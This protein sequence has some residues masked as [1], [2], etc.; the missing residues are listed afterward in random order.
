M[1]RTQL[2]WPAVVVV[3]LLVVSARYGVAENCDAWRAVGFPEH[4]GCTAGFIS[5]C[6]PTGPT[7]VWRHHEAV[8]TRSDEDQDTDCHRLASCTDYTDVDEDTFTYSWTLEVETPTYPFVWEK[9]CDLAGTSTGATWSTTADYE[10]ERYYR[11]VCWVDDTPGDGPGGDDP[12][13]MAASGPV[14]LC[15]NFIHRLRFQQGCPSQETY[16]MKVYVEWDASCAPDEERHLGHLD[17]VEFRELVNHD[18]G[19]D[20]HDC[21]HDGGN[22]FDHE[23]PNPWTESRAGTL[24]EF[25]DTYIWYGWGDNPLKTSKCYCTQKLQYACF[26]DDAPDENDWMNLWECKVTAVIEKEGDQWYERI[27]RLGNGVPAQFTVSLPIQ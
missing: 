14:F 7:F 2:S 16:G 8:F 17:K 22:C 11:A 15:A 6:Q 25:L 21:G 10:P 23:E 20:P 18:N 3:S 5:A 12:P 27:E 1:P 4:N 24:G 9:V 19:D 26:W 13:Q